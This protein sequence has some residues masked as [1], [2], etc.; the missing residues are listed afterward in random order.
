MQK[1]RK[2]SRGK[3]QRDNSQR[4]REDWGDDWTARPK[5]KKGGRKSRHGKRDMYGDY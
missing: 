2:R 5:G 1:R 3:Q 4:M